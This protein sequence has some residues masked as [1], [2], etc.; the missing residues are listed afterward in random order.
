MEELQADLSLVTLLSCRAS[1]YN[2]LK[3]RVLETDE[4]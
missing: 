1:P 4:Q 2:E 3:Q